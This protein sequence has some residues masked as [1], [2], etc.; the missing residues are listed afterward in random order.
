VYAANY[1]IGHGVFLQMVARMM[2]S[3]RSFLALTASAAAQSQPPPHPGDELVAGSSLE[4][5]RDQYRRDL[6]EDFLPFMDRHIIDHDLGGFLC[7]ADRDGTVLSQDKVTWYEGRGTWVYSFLYNHFG[8]NPKHLEVARKSVALILPAFPSNGEMY[9]KRFTRDGKP[10]GEPDP[11]IYSDMFVAEGLAEFA[12][13][14]GERRYR[15]LAK[16]LLLKCV[17]RYDRPDYYPRI[18]ETY[19]GSGAKAFPGA[20]VLGCWMVLLRAATQM[21]ETQADT[22][23]AQVCDR[24]VNAIVEHHFNPAFALMNEL[25][26]HDLSRPDSEYVQLVYTGHS[27]ETLWMVM[28]EG[29][30]RG[31]TQ[32]FNTAAERFRR[33]VE[34]AWDDVYGGVFRNLQNVDANVWSVDK[35][36]WAQAEVLIGALM[37]YEHTRAAWARD[38]FSKMYL[39]VQD[40]Y[41]LRRHGLPLWIFSA[42]RKV[43]FERHS[44]RIENYHHPRHLMLNLLSLER[45]IAARP[46]AHAAG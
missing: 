16:E 43:T 33:H 12:K 31:D 17:A 9:V 32:L 14:T 24:S 28:A 19:L 1:D 34:V 35:V 2:A 23:I 8:H 5:L 21:L 18:G 6:F 42:D 4:R 13:A 22:E 15:Q 20:R 38:L 41:P 44:N 37:V 3:R 40:K 36:L 26:N 30:R 45:M 11:E 7:T 25:L 10:V 27:I 46:E 29:R 39:Y